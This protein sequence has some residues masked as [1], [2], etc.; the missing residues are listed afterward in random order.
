MMFF[1]TWLCAVQGKEIE[2]VGVINKRLIMMK[3]QYNARHFFIEAFTHFSM[4][5]FLHS[6]ISTFDY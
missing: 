2:V 6:Y 3:L 5:S 1:C 4:R